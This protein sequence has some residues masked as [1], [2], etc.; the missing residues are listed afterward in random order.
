MPRRSIVKNLEALKII[1]KCSKLYRDN[2]LNSN[3]LF[4]F[5][6]RD[7][8]QYEYYEMLFLSKHFLHLTGVETQHSAN[9]FYD[10]CVNNKLKESDFKLRSDGTTVLKLEVL[11]KLMNIEQEA[12]MIGQFKAG[13]LKLHTEKLAGNIRAGMGFVMD[14]CNYYVPNTALQVDV[15]DFVY[16]PLKIYAIYKKQCTCEKY[17]LT[18]LAKKTNLSELKLPNAIKIKLSIS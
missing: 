13:T 16:D 15:R 10:K 5:Q 8:K 12:C 18:Y 3:L 7:T 17:K 11:E 6:N 1:L 14:E 9:A 2:L 4:L